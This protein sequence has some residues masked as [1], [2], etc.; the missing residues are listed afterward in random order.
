[1]A[2]LRSSSSS[3]SEATVTGIEIASTPTKLTYTVGESLD[4]A[5]LS[6]RVTKSDGSTETVTSGF[7]CSPNK[8]STAGN[9]AVTVSYKEA[10]TSFSVTVNEVAVTSISVA[11]SPAKLVYNVGESLDTTGLEITANKADG[12]TETVTSGFTVSPS[13]ALNT[14]GDNTISVSYKGCTTTFT[15]KVNPAQTSSAPETSTETSS[16]SSSE[17]S[18]ST[19]SSVP[20]VSLPESS[21]PESTQPESS[22]PESSVPE[23]TQPEENSGEA[24]AVLVGNLNASG[25]NGKSRYYEQSLKDT[26]KVNGKTMSVYDAVCQIVAYEAGK[27]Q[28]EEHVKAQAVASYTYLMNGGGNI[29]AGLSTAKLDSRTERLVA[30]VIGY[31]VLDDRSKDFILAVYFSESCGETANAEW[32]WGYPNRNLLS[33]SS[34]VDG[35]TT[36]TY[37][38]SSS[39]FKSKVEGK[40]N[41]RLSG[42]PEDWIDIYSYWGNSDYVNE[43]KLCGTKYSARK[44]RETVLGT[45]NLRSTAFDVEYDSRTDSFVFTMRGYGHGVGMSAV[46]S[47]EYAKKGYSWDEILMKYYSNCYIGFKTPR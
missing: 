1:M 45:A 14:A 8:F 24:N 22:V 25:K 5:G 42:D 4:T 7:S 6:L 33:V 18:S 28:P 26:V 13:G 16:P 3:S 11:K 40:T 36:K 37:K 35:K 17:P 15:V 19:P 47:I 46:G 27:G 39:D 20:E 34:P 30:E 44:L 9:V 21:V 43:V 29:S 31:A 41:I 12:T 38:I 10:T 2:I 32:V 23:S